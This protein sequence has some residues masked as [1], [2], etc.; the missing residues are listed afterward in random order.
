MIVFFFIISL[1]VNRLDEVSYDDTDKMERDTLKIVRIDNLIEEI[2][3]QYTLP[4]KDEVGG[5]MN[6]TR[7]EGNLVMSYYITEDL[8]IEN[9]QSMENFKIQMDEMKNEPKKL[10]NQNTLQ[11]VQKN[12]IIFIFRHYLK[13][14]DKSE[15]LINEIQISPNEW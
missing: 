3:S 14:K 2:E 6:I 5:L 8:F 15:R 12:N 10:I 13:S 11:F 4:Y 9:F 1:I 7:E